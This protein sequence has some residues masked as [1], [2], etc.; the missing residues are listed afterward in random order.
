MVEA[1]LKFWR[2]TCLCFRSDWSC[3]ICQMMKGS[4]Q[5]AATFNVCSTKDTHIAAL[6]LSPL[7]LGPCVSLFKLQPT[8]F[9]YVMSI[10][11][12]RLLLG[13]DVASSCGQWL[14]FPFQNTQHQRHQAA[15]TT[16]SLKVTGV[17]QYLH[18]PAPQ[19]QLEMMS[20]CSLLTTY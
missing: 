2:R 10:V 16:P 12:Y 9:G 17:I 8:L 14:L 4:K 3:G 13:L 20:L 15:A 11:W 5:A 7:C 18:C 1:K 19:R 6:P